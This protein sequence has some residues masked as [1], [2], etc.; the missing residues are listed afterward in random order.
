MDPQASNTTQQPTA[1]GGLATSEIVK[2]LKPSTGGEGL[3]RAEL[4]E[5][6][7]K[8]AVEDKDKSK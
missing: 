2:N 7:A 6:K 1:T 4:A 3:T 5:Q 8:A